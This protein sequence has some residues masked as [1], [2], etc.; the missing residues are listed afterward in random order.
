M[1][2]AIIGGDRDP[3]AARLIV[4]VGVAWLLLTLWSVSRY[5]PYLNHEILEHIPLALSAEYGALLLLFVAGWALMV[6]AMMLPGILPAVNHFRRQVGR[7]QS[8]VML[9]MGYVTVW[10][11]FG[12]MAHIGDVFVHEATHRFDRLAT[13]EWVLTAAL[14]ALAGLYQFTPYKRTCLKAWHALG[15]SQ[16]SRRAGQL[17]LHYGLC[18]VGSCG[19]LMLL[20]F[21]VACGNVLVMLILGAIMAAEKKAPWGRRVSAPLGA[22]LFGL[23]VIASLIGT[24]AI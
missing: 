4:L 1:I 8:A 15:E 22:L 19:P 5:A 16:R 10:T 23:G 14:F 6:V 3:F 17:G 13:N 7:T 24:G 9:I 11:I 21:G 12:A 2:D 20:M 18:C